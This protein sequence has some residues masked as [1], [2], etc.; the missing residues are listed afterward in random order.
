MKE[1]RRV[2][3]LRESREERKEKMETETLGGE[4]FSNTFSLQAELTHQWSG[5][6]GIKLNYAGHI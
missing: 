3:G 5:L 1:E 6:V 2:R 4:P